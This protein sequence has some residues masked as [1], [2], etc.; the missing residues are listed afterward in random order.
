M[1]DLEIRS[2]LCGTVLDLIRDESSCQ[3]TNPL[4]NKDTRVAGVFEA[5][6]ILSLERV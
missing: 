3:L 6:D 1:H 5:S 2:Q 4:A